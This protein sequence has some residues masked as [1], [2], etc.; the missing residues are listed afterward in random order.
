MNGQKSADHAKDA[1]ALDD[2]AARNWTRKGS[3]PV[4]LTISAR[5][6]PRSAGTTKSRF[7]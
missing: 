7:T 3:S 1:A 6:E 2:W 4:S 5:A